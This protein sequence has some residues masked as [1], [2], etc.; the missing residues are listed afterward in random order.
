MPSV[1]HHRVATVLGG[2]AVL[3]AGV[4]VWQ[5]VGVSSGDAASPEVAWGSSTYF[6]LV[7]VALAALAWA[8]TRGSRWVSGPAVVVQVLSMPLAVSMATEGLWVGAVLLGGLGATG[9]WLLLGPAGREAFER[10]RLEG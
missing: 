10:A 9:L 8:C 1:Q 7:G 2:Q 3:A 6:V 4:G 5:L